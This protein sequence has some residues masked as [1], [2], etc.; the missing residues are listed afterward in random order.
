MDRIARRRVAEEL[1]AARQQ[2]DSYILRG[3]HSG[4][5]PPTRIIRKMGFP[6]RGFTWHIQGDARQLDR[7]ELIDAIIKDLMPAAI[8]TSIPKVERPENI[9]GFGTYLYPH[10]WVGEVPTRSAEEILYGVMPENL[11]FPTKAFDAE[12]KSRKLVVNRDG[13][14]A[15]EANSP[16][17]ATEHLNEIIST[18]SPLNINFIAVREYEVGQADIIP[19]NLTIGGPTHPMASIRSTA[20][21]IPFGSPW[22]SPPINRPQ[23]SE[24]S[25]KNVISNAESLM[26]DPFIKSILPFLLEARTH[27]EASE[28]RQC[29]VMS[30]LVVET[31]LRREWINALKDQGV[32]KSRM[33]K[34]T[35]T[36]TWTAD[37]MSEALSL[38]GNIDVGMLSSLS[39][40][41]R[42]RNKVVHEGYSP[43]E[44]EAQQALDFAVKLLSDL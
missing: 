27:F 37:V 12:Y 23:I 24:E 41:R 21:Q 34:L 39:S 19:G 38:L 10:I 1:F 31:W 3:L 44:K 36:G 33:K 17:E 32:S 9:R 22:L 5:K 35:E 15:I 8:S 18:A 30:W 28:Y 7:K 42:R 20:F 6:G 4:A 25:L 29:F 14:M 2:I 13:F 43:S 40:H 26:S 11:M 16:T